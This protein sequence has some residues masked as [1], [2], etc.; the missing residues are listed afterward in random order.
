MQNKAIEEI[1]IGI[2][3]ISKVVSNNTATS[4]ESAAAASDLAGRSAAFE[5]IVARF[6]LKK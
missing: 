4:E 3:Q 1:N 5:G 6:K 2:N